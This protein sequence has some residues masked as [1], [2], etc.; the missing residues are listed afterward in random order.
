MIIV[1]ARGGLCNRMRTICSVIEG[2]R[3]FGGTWIVLWKRYPD[4][5]SYFSDLFEKINGLEVI[6][7]D[8]LYDIKKSKI[9]NYTLRLI[10]SLFK[11]IPGFYYI[12]ELG[13]EKMCQQGT[14]RAF[15]KKHRFVYI[16]TTQNFLSNNNYSIFKPVDP[17]LSAVY[18]YSNVIGDNTIGVH[19][20]RTDNVWSIEK[21]PTQLFIE[22]MNKEIVQNFNV[23]FYLSTD[24]KDV[25]NELKYLFKDRIITYE[26]AQIN[27]DTQEGIKDA[28][29][30]LYN[31]SKCTKIYGSYM[32][33]FS[34]VAAYISNIEKIII[35][36]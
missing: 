28:A 10:S 20:R 9:K 35:T 8:S 30:D 36:K 21:S 33:S 25:E 2:K 4:L 17:I 32:S 1:E 27:R 29:I 15:L 3:E 19:I 26:K 18:Q 14:I 22:M 31:L 11:Y 5:N 16:E 13:S 7:Y 23:N 24:D 6:D 12:S 34:D